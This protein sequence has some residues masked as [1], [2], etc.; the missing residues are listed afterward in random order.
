MTAEGCA[1]I[2]AGCPNAAVAL[3]QRVVVKMFLYSQREARCYG[4]LVLLF[5]LVDRAEL[6]L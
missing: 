2:P 3:G 1:V 5:C 4:R 6:T